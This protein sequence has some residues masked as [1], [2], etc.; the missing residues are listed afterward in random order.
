MKKLGILLASLFVMTLATQQLSAQNDASVAA[1]AKATILNGLKIV[2]N[3]D[4]Q[5]GKI[6]A[7]ST[8]SKV[9]IQT[10][11]SRT[12]S[13]GDVVLFNTGSDH[14]AA[15]FTLTGTATR[16]YSLDLPTNVTLTGP[17]GSSPM[18]VVGFV[19][20]ATGTLSSSSEEFAVGATLN[21]G[22]N[23]TAGE[24]TGTFTVTAAYN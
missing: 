2:K 4:L 3:A 6:V 1:N 14:Q 16:P 13:S 5:F 19:H 21:V 10:D 20:N 8:V 11:G 18:T 22:A 24:Y 15:R 17:S 12:I 23:Q 7:G 9:Q